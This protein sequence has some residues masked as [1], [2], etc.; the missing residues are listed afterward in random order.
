[1]LHLYKYMHATFGSIIYNYNDFDLLISKYTD[2]PFYT[3][4]LIFTSK[5]AKLP[6]LY[7]HLSDVLHP[8]LVS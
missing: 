7:E 8:Y 2:N 4:Y 5:I 3:F 1:M 6:L